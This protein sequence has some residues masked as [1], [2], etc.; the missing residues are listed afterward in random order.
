MTLVAAGGNRFHPTAEVGERFGA[1]QPQ[2]R[3]HVRALRQAGIEEL[4]ARPGGIAEFAQPDHARAALERVEGAPQRGHV[5]LAVGRGLQPFQGRGGV[6]HHLARFFD[7]DVAHLGIVFEPGAAHRCGLGRRHRGAGRN[8]LGRVRCRQPGHGS[9]QLGAQRAPGLR[10]DTFTQAGIGGAEQ[11]R[12]LGLIGCQRLLREALGVTRQRLVADLRQRRRGA[13]GLHLGQQRHLGRG[14]GRCRIVELGKG[15]DAVGAAHHRAQAARGGVE[16]EQRF[17]QLRL[18]AEHVDEEAQG[19]QVVGQAVEGAGLDGALRVDLG[20]RQRV[21]VVAHVQ[22]GLRGLVHA[23]HREH[24]AHRAQLRWHRDQHLTLGRVAEVLVD[25]L[26]DL[27][28]RGPQL[29]HHAAHGLAV[30]DA[31]VELL[32]PHVQRL[33][34]GALAHLVDAPRQ[35]LDAFGQLGLVELAVFERCVEVEDAGGHFHGQRGRRRLARRHRL[36]RRPQQRLRQHLARGEQALQGFADERELLGQAGD[37]VLLAAGHRRPGVLGRGDP[38]ARQRQVGRIE[39]AQAGGFI[40]GQRVILQ[41]PDAAYRVQPRRRVGRGRRLRAAAEEEQVLRQAVRRLGLPEHTRAQLRQQPRGHALGEDVGAQQARG[42]G[43]VHRRGQLPQCGQTGVVVGPRAS[44]QVGAEV[45]HAPQRR[46]ARLAHERQHFGFHGAARIFVGDARCRGEV[47]GQ[48]EPLPVVLPQ[49]SR[50]DA[51]GTGQG[52]SGAVLREQHHRRHRLARQQPGQEVE[53]REGH[54]LD[55][56]DRGRV[57]DGRLADHAL[58]GAFAGTQYVG[59]RGQA[60]EFE[61]THALVQLRACAAQQR[62]IDDVEVAAADR[63][64]VLEVATQRLVR[65]FERALEL[66]MDP[67]QRAEVV[68]G[69]AGQAS[70]LGIHGVLHRS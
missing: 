38:L 58:H 13:Q 47:L 69:Q 24:A 45:A 42:L 36:R 6:G 67:G 40:V 9:G 28:Q 3:I 61:R 27:G 41:A 46:A 29:L 14:A 37:A 49:V 4:L 33:R 55:H 19:A 64:C 18:H 56:L 10:F 34:L 53:Q 5:R 62:R 68:A 22:R 25:L 2:R 57:D 65:G 12:Q 20:L 8:R 7:E 23:Q 60:D 48:L 52:Q 1:E 50:M 31:A 30:G 43:F 17:G 70:G 35:A 21:N 66:A 44:A 16:S 39:A 32:H 63:L 51:V 26:F 54:A 59:H 15:R 11:P